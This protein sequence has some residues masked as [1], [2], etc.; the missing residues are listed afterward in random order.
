MRVSS[1][2]WLKMPMGIAF[3][4][5]NRLWTAVLAAN[6]MEKLINRASQL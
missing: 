3:H 2:I 6:A 5:Q 4:K 1:Q